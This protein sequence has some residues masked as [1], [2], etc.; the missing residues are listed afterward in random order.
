[1]FWVVTVLLSSSRLD[2]EMVPLNPT[3]QWTNCVSFLWHVTLQGWN[4]DVRSKKKMASPGDAQGS[5]SIIRGQ[6]LTHCGL[7]S[8][9]EWDNGVIHRDRVKKLLSTPLS[10]WNEDIGRLA[11]W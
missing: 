3:G 2:P 5:L 7:I 6:R 11:V 9:R 4:L 10:F 1:M 8:F